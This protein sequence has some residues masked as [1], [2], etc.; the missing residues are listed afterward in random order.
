MK[1]SSFEFR[2]RVWIIAALYV[3]GFTAPWER[4]VPALQGGRMWSW[5][6][7]VLFRTGWIG[8]QQAFVAVLI[9]AIVLASAGAC[10]R[11]WATAYLGAETMQGARMMGNKVVAAGPYRY[12]RNPL[13]LG[14]W[15]SALAVTLAMSRSGAL[16]FVVALA[17]FALRLM[18][19]EE[20][21]LT[22][23]QGEAYFAYRRAVPMLLPR[24][25]R[26]MPDA[27]E[28]AGGVLRP[29]WARSI[30]AETFA[31]G[32]ALCLAVFG[33][34]YDSVLL[35]RCVV[36]CFGVSLVVGAALLPKVE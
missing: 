25:R 11:V 14:L 7:L 6:A 31:V 17:V 16:F 10:L 33:W 18:A 13:Y 30:P 2:Y 5:L 3:L 19:G 36:V 8:P 24:L 26:L 34:R 9:A 15:L 32:V 12:I 21:Y 29:Q 22:Q 1:S 4:Y 23:Q 20:A 28:R 35:I 27:K